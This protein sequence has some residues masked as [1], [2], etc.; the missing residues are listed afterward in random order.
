MLLGLAIGIKFLPAAALPYLLFRRFGRAV[1]YALITFALTLAIGAV[2]TRPSALAHYLLDLLPALGSGNGYRENQSL[3][4]FFTRLCS[5]GG[6]DG[7]SAGPGACARGLTVGADAALFAGLWLA[8]A[9]RSLWELSESARYRR[10][11]LEYGLAVLTVPLVASI[12][13]GLHLVL[14][15]LPIAILLRYLVA[16]RAFTRP[17]L[18][19]LIV[20][21]ACFSVVRGAFY[22]AILHPFPGTPQIAMRLA[23]ESYVVGLLLLWLLVFRV[24]RSA[25]AV[26]ARE[27][28]PGAR[29]AA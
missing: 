10:R 7:A 20:A 2:V 29:R 8:T 24:L 28:R 21:L 11:A 6:L 5:P 3:L 27:S 9:R 22:M 4:G 19:A 14:V 18:V 15:L 12:S 16:D 13:W 25:D 23:S 17:R 26:A 1:L